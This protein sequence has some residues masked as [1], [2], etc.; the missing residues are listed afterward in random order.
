[1]LVEWLAYTGQFARALAIGTPFVAAAAD[2]APP[3]HADYADAWKGLGIAYAHLGR[4]DEARAAFD[5]ARDRNREREHA[6]EIYAANVNELHLV[7]RS[8]NLLCFLP[9]VAGGGRWCCGC[10]R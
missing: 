3:W 2:I 7:R 10:V 6:T 1:M 4:P 8:S 5:R 9:S